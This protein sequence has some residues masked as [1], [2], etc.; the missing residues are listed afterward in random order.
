VTIA[1]YRSTPVFDETTLP[2]ALR[3]RHSTGAGI[4]GVI[5]V[6]QGQVRLNYLDPPSQ[7]ILDGATRGALLPGQLHFVEPLGPFKMQIDFYDQPPG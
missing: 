2:S 5:R 7:I 1:P 3:N 4:W 6:M